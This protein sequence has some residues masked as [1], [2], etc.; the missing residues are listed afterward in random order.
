MDYKMT[1][2]GIEGRMYNRDRTRYVSC[3]LTDECKVDYGLEPMWF[4]MTNSV[5]NPFAPF[6]TGHFGITEF[7]KAEEWCRSEM[8][9]CD[10]D[11]EESKCG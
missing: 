4:C 9:E 2:E 7:S 1:W 8:I 5:S 3:E 10:K 6:C 11:L